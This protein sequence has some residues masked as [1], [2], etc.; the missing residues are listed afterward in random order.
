MPVS[1]THGNLRRSLPFERQQGW[2][3]SSTLDEGSNDALST[4]T[5][6]QQCHQMNTVNEGL[7]QICPSCLTVKVRHM[8]KTIQSTTRQNVLS[9]KCNVLHDFGEDHWLQRIE[10]WSLAIDQS[11]WSGQ[12][13]KYSVPLK[14]M[15]HIYRA[16]STHWLTVS[17]CQLKVF[18]LWWIQYYI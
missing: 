7:P 13:D 3:Y 14:L 16:H 10:L 6:C 12:V 11:Y 9:Q 8:A 2:E 15:P 17:N 4:L 18:H 5:Y 1:L